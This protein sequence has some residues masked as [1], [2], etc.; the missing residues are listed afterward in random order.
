MTKF[1]MVHVLLQLQVF[2]ERGKDIFGISNL[3]V[4]SFLARKRYFEIYRL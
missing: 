3:V 4:P 2:I 1:D